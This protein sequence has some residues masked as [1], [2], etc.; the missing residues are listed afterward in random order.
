VKKVFSIVLA[1][2]LVLTAVVVSAVPAGAVTPGTVEVCLSNPINFE[3]SDYCIYFHNGSLLKEAD[4]DFI[5]IIFPTGT[6]CTGHGAIT[7]YKSPAPL[8]AEPPCGPCACPPTFYGSAT[9]YGREEVSVSAQPVNDESI[10]LTL[11]GTDEYIEKCNFVLIIIEDVVNPISCEHHLEVGSSTHTPVDSEPYTIYCAKIA[12]NG[13][14]NPNT[15]L[16]VM[17][18]VSLPC[19]PID[20]SIEAVLADLFIWKTITA[21][22]AKPFTFSVWY[23]D[24]VAKTWLK[25]VSDT[26]FSDLQTIETGKAYW[27]KPSRDV[28]IYIHGYPYIAGQGPPVKWCYPF[29]WNMVGYASTSNTMLLGDYLQ[30]TIIPPA[31]DS[32]V[33]AVWWFDNGPTTQLYKDTGWRRDAD[34]TDPAGTGYNFVMTAGMGYWMAFVAEACIIPPA[35]A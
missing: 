28:T 29:S 11:D 21:G 3:T 8:P 1:L 34:T 10:R 30:Y 35:P 7:V 31:Y 18:L 13:G 27:I 5:D 26:S 4:S 33:L 15:G 24:N 17:N 16:A 32:A 22:E 19:Y 2:A 12:L 23:W 9:W 20:T 14:V 6:N 25:Y